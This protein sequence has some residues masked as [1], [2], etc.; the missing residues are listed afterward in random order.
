MKTAAM[1]SIEVKTV[2]SLAFFSLLT[3]GN[4][5]EPVSIP[6]KSTKLVAYKVT[7]QTFWDQDKFPKM[8][9][10]WRPPAQWSK[11]VGKEIVRYIQTSI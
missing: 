3:G 5:S 2:L 8:Y 6:C 7:F 1:T 4:G 10:E 9:P 11:L